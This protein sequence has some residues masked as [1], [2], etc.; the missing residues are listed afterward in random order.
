MHRIGLRLDKLER[1]LA[2]VDGPRETLRVLV[3]G[4]TMASSECTRTLCPDGT[5][6]ECVRLDGS[7][8]ELPDGELERFIAS[9]PI[10]GVRQ[11]GVP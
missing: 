4:W 9:F 6:L 8:A 2:T 10:E 7:G 1:S 11:R 5:L 3:R